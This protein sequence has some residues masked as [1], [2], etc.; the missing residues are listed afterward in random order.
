[1]EGRPLCRPM[2]IGTGRRPSLQCGSRAAGISDPGYR[3][4][5]RG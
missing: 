2:I 3:L 4:P 5:K 1:M